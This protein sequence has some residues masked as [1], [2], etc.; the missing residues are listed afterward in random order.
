MELLPLFVNLRGRRVL[1]VGGGPVAAAK[2]APLVDAGAD[3]IVV[4]PEVVPAIAAAPV[5]VRRR[6]FEPRDL[7][8][9]WLAVAAAT[10]E[11][12]AQ[13]AAAAETRRVIVNAV[14]DPANASAY[15]GGIVRRAGVTIAISTGGAAPG[16]T[17]LLRQAIEALLPRDVGDWI[18][19]AARARAGWR[20]CGVPMDARRPLLLE[21]LNG[22]YDR[23]GA[24]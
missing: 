3:L 15:F 7:D 21:T 1:L 20:R 16:L 17:A 11:V 9:V 2:L 22:L 8:D 10:R 4:S 23:K 13:V 18:E 5:T 6:P 14:D 12:N 24:A 19:A